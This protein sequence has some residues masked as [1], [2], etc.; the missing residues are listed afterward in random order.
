MRDGSPPQIERTNSVAEIAAGHA[1]FGIDAALESIARVGHDPELA[2]GL[3]DIRRVPQRAL[4]QNVAR[5]LVAAGMLA[6][7]DSGDRFDAV[8]V[9][10][11]D[12]ALVERV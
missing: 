6:A 2:A 4:D 8:G 3:G 7:H 11:D 5:R 12:H 1:E 10:D 9:G